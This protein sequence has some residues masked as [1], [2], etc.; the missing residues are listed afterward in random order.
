M[1]V[2]IVHERAKGVSRP[3]TSLS[4]SLGPG[5]TA[6]DRW[7]TEY[8]CVTVKNHL[9][10]VDSRTAGSYPTVELTKQL[11]QGGLL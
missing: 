11:P 8:I 1:E 4:L 3:K 10:E 6:R 5:P 7:P 2:K 9:R